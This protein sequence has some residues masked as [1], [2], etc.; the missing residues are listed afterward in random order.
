VWQFAMPPNSEFTT[1]CVIMSNVFL[2][3]GPQFWSLPCVELEYEVC[4][5]QLKWF[6]QFLLD[7]T[8]FSRLKR[9]AKHLMSPASLMT[10]QWAQ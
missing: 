7:G 8:V 4:I 3:V 6:A 9:F 5:N 2:V 10:K 1:V